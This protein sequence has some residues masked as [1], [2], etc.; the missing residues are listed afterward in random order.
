MKLFAIC[1]SGRIKKRCARNELGGK[2]GPMSQ[3]IHRGLCVVRR[4]GANEDKGVGGNYWCSWWWKGCGW[5]EKEVRN[6][7]MGWCV[8]RKKESQ[9]YKIK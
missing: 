4:N 7:V 9:K 2:K 5:I 8:E 3:A 6:G 1:S